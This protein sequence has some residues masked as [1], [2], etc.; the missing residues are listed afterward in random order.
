MD[1]KPN[2]TKQIVIRLSPQEH[3]NIIKAAGFA[4]R[5][6]SDW[7]RVGMTEFAAHEINKVLDPDDHEEL[8][9]RIIDRVF[10]KG[11]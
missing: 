10:R 1:R 5:T 8:R 2:R 4:N 6:V 3:S 9:K 7:S 11:S